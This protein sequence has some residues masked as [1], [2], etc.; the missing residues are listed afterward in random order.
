MRFSLTFAGTRIPGRVTAAPTRWVKDHVINRRFDHLH[1]EGHNLPWREVR[2]KFTAKCA[3]HH[4]LEDSAFN[5]C[6]FKCGTGINQTIA[7]KVPH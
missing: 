4:L 3:A 7:L 6:A 5:V 1:H 2:A